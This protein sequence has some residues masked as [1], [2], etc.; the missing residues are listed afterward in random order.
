MQSAFGASEQDQELVETEAELNRETLGS[1]QFI[2]NSMSKKNGKKWRSK[3]FKY[4]S[5][6]QNYS[7]VS[8]FR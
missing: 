2:C 5:L 6:S 7:F 3:Y 4:E 1:D 8:M